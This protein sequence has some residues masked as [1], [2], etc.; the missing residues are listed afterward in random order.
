MMFS[1]VFL[2]FLS[3]FYLLFISHIFCCSTLLKTSQM[4]FEMIIMVFDAND[5]I[6]AGAFLGPFCFSLFIFLVVFVCLSMFI[7]I[8]MDN[9]RHARENVNNSEE[10]FSFMWNRF[11]RWT[12]RFVFILLCYMLDK[13]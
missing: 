3:L 1:I 9:F 10:I 5:L 11:V 4:L 6:E 12:G 2:A 8:I 13:F 7:A